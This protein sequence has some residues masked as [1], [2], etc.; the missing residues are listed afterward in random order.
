MHER[1]GV[2]HLDKYRTNLWY[3]GRSE[4]ERLYVLLHNNNN[5][6]E[7]T[8]HPVCRSPLGA[9]V[10]VLGGYLSTLYNTM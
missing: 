4:P 6:N 5:N 2:P 7:L 3:S 1:G 9:L 8:G 10:L